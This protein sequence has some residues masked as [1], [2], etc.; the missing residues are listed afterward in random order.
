MNGEGSITISASGGGGAGGATEIGID[1]NTSPGTNPV[2]PD[3]GDVIAIS[4]GQVSSSTIGANVIRT[5][6]T[7]VNELTIEIQGSGTNATTDSI[8]NGVCHFDSGQ[9]TS[10][11]NS[12]IQ[13]A[14][15]APLSFPTDS[16]TATPAANALTVAGGTGLNTSGSGATVTV[17]LDIPVIVANGG[18]GA[19]SLGDGFVLL[20]SGTGAVTALDVTVQ[21]SILVGDGTTDPIALPVGTDDQVL[22][23]DQSEPSGLKWA[24]SAAAG[25]A[26]DFISTATAS[27]SATISFTGL[28][29]TY[30][31]YRIFI[32]NLAPASDSVRF[33]ISTS[34]DNG[35]SYDAGSS[36]Y[37]WGVLY[38]RSQT[39]P[40]LADDGDQTDSVIQMS[41]TDGAAWGNATNEVSFL[42]V[43]IFNP[44][45]T[46]YT[47][48]MI[49]G[50]Y[51]ADDG[52]IVQI[53]GIG[54]RLSAAD[55]D[56][57]QFAF[58]SGN[59]ATGTFKLY[60]LNAS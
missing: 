40:N 34:S 25:G 30:F 43:S 21:G 24:T 50:K 35:S 22:T 51:T 55:V 9:F 29:S 58:S 60:G 38:L 23:A 5:N 42:E 13:L 31:M 10:D 27:A 18:T 56:A 52:D 17:A 12:F 48:M 41:D 57:I 39:S 8:F 3:G 53:N 54:T 19:T 32:D 16:G 49:K 20:G 59:I 6:S 44:S 33:Y 36:D 7:V 28:N 2:V 26:W 14:A 46:Q 37:A 1:V 11:S 47:T 45:Q 15:T 4:G